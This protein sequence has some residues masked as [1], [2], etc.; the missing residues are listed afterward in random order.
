MK[1]RVNPLVLAA[2]L[3]LLGPAALEAEEDADSPVGQWRRSDPGGD[4]FPGRLGEQ[5]E[6]VAIEDRVFIDDGLGA[7]LADRGT[8]TRSDDNA[9]RQDLSLASQHV[10]REFRAEQGALAVITRVEEG[11]ELREFRDVYTRLG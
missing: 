1:L 8:W 11:G 5:I 4:F 3:G 7:G 10:S 9:L 6:V 2:A